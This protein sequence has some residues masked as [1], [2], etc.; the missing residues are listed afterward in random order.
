DVASNPK[1]SPMK[2]YFAPGTCSM[3]PHIILCESGLPHTLVRVST[4]THTTADGSDY[5]KINPKGQVP[6]LE[7]D[8]GSLLTEGPIIVQYIP[9]RAGGTDLMPAAGTLERYRV[10]EWQSYVGTEIHKSFSP[11]FNPNFDA[12][13][14][15]VA[16]QILRRKLEWVDGRLA[17][18]SFLTG[19][20]FTGADAYLYAVV[21]WTKP[22]G[23]D[24]GD[25][26]NL[27]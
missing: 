13:A 11:L 10:M 15:G 16:K 14:K 25:L 12:T 9:A 8:D 4:K 24:I 18:R 5:Y 27:Q 17:G 1:G 22:V 20:T 2:L 26:A 7:L 19:E 21:G 6:V 23:I 3:A